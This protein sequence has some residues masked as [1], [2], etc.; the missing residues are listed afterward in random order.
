MPISIHS[1]LNKNKK[2]DLFSA[3]LCLQIAILPDLHFDYLSRASNT[4]QF[5]PQSHSKCQF[6]CFIFYPP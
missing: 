1:T 6:S 2:L 4:E 5:F 3:L